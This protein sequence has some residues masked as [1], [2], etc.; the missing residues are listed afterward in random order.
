MKA[1]LFDIDGTLVKVGGAG[2]EAL[3]RAV[4]VTLGVPVKVARE[5]AL[6]L[7][8]RGRTDT[9]LI[10][11]IVEGV[12][13]RA[14]TL[15]PRIIGAYLGILDEV[16][17]DARLE[18]M[19]GVAAVLQALEARDDVVVGLLT[20]NLRE[21]ARRKLAP[22]GLGYLADRPGGFGEDGRERQDVARAAVGR[23]ANRRVEPRRVVVVG[24]TEHDVAA[25]KSAG[26]RA[27]AV[28]TGWTAPEV[29]RDCGADLALADLA[30][31]ELLA[32]IE[33]L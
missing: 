12:G 25:A 11:Q 7:D 19:P 13:G 2:R 24:D 4:A 18:V 21:G 16:L 22:F 26:A 30:G 6:R 8:F 1:V 33:T 28:A 27:V 3:A 14:P 17:A 5:A 15:D 31:P 9:L 23:L 10:D 20:G 32:L 29:L